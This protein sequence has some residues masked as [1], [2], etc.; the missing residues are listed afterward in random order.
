MTKN[1][2]VDLLEIYHQIYGIKNFV[3]R[4][5]TI[6]LYSKQDKFYVDGKE[7]LIGYRRLIDMAKNGDVMQVWGDPYRV[8]DMVYVKDFCQMLMKA[9]NVNHSHGYYM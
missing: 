5:P 1:F 4:L 9:L 3:F 8:K 2:A 6:Y 7:R